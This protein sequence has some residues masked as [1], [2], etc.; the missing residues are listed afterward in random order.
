M[1]G[2][3]L[4]QTHPALTFIRLG[5]CIESMQVA[6]EPQVINAQAQIRKQVLI[7]RRSNRRVERPS[8]PFRQTGA[9]LESAFRMHA[10]DSGVGELRGG[11][12]GH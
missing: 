2:S 6:F 5:V 3:R 9:P 7:A 4:A 1:I 11:R 12:G 10:L 8:P